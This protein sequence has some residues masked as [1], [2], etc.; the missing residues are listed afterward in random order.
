MTWG[1]QE[2]LGGFDF[3]NCLIP[4]IPVQNFESTGP[5]LWKAV[6]WA[7][8]VI[9]DCMYEIFKMLRYDKHIN[10]CAIDHKSIM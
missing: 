1:E 9:S 4:L 8:E 10:F 7:F 2:K 3:S 5:A 6:S